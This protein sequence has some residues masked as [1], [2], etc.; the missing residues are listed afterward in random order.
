M[1]DE[2]AYILASTIQILVLGFMII[3]GGWTIYDAHKRGRTKVE[4]LVWGLFVAAFF[5]VGFITYM[6]LRTRLYQE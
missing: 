3:T 2:V 5:L 6:L 1:T 4:A